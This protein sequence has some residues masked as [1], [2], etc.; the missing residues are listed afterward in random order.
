MTSWT[1]VVRRWVTVRIDILAGLFSSGLAVYLVYGSG[2][3]GAS[4]V[5]QTHLEI[6]IVLVIRPLILLKDTAPRTPLPV[7]ERGIESAERH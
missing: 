4:K 7:L 1:H 3:L 5:S 2:N 6:P